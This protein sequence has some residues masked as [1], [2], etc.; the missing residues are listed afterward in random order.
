MAEAWDS[1]QRLGLADARLLVHSF[2][3]YIE[4]MRAR[5]AA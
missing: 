3:L 5:A 1:D 2:P 4:L